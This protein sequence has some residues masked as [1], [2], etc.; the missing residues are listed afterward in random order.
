MSGPSSESSPLLLPL[1]KNGREAKNATCRC[2]PGAVLRRAFPAAL[3]A[4]AVALLKSHAAMAPKK[5]PASVKVRLCRESLP[6]CRTRTAL[7][8]QGQEGRHEGQ[9]PAASVLSWAFKGCTECI[10][11]LRQAVV[12]RKPAA[13][14]AASKSKARK[15]A[16]GARGQGALCI[17]RARL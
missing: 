7:L 16:C 10:D 9:A 13:S 2:P 12:K 6:H 1:Q 8:G 3:P 17:W 11:L 15:A 14:K 5:K 4:Q